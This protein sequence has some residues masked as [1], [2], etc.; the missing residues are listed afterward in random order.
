MSPCLHSDDGK[1]VICRPTITNRRVTISKCPTCKKKR[2]F[3]N[4]FQ[5]WYGWHSTC[6]GCGEQWADGEMI[7]RPFQRGWRELNIEGAKKDIRLMR[8]KGEN[9]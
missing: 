7:E 1:L 3:F 9:K 8:L 6:T 5:E 4:W 2:Q